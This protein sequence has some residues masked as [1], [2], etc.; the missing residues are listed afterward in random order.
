[1]QSLSR[2]GVAVNPRARPTTCIPGHGEDPRWLVTVRLCAA[3][4]TVES[5][6]CVR[7][8]G[9]SY[10]SSAAGGHTSRRVLRSGCLR[11]SA[12]MN[13]RHVE[14]GGANGADNWTLDPPAANHGAWGAS[15]L[16]ALRVPNCEPFEH[17]VTTARRRPVDEIAPTSPGGSDRGGSSPSAS[18]GATAACRN[19]SR[20]HVTPGAHPAQYWD[21]FRGAPAGGGMGKV[22]TVGSRGGSQHSQRH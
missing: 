6:T 11:A 15:W 5:Q 9:T 20:R 3:P 13:W 19:R 7:L 18:G 17:E 21:R 4:T 12:P 22:G 16:W 2:G 1:M 14:H 10:R 8:G